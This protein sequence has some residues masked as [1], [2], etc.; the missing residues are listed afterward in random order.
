MRLD[1]VDLR[2]FYDTPLG[3]AAQ[4]MIARRIQAL[5][6]DA[7]GLDM[8]GIGYATPFLDHYRGKARRV[9]SAMPGAQGPCSS[10]K[11]AAWEPGSRLT[12]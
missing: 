5:W 3:A 2:R 4:T 9:A 10:T 11:A 1:V 6:P 8:A 7:R 12:M